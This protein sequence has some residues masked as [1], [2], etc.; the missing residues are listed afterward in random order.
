MISHKHYSAIL[1]FQQDSGFSWTNVLGMVMQLLFP[2][3]A[4][5]P[6]KSDAI[7]S[8]QVITILPFFNDKLAQQNNWSHRTYFARSSI[9]LFEIRSQNRGLNKNEG[10]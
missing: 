1:T 9:S 7:D 5:G 8:D 4:S 2:P 10:N 6:S 3:N